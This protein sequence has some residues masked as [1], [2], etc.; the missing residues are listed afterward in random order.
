MTKLKNNMIL[1]TLLLAM[2]CCAINAAGEDR[3]ENVGQVTALKN[4]LFYHLFYDAMIYLVQEINL[5]SHECG[6]AVVGKILHPDKSVHIFMHL[7]SFSDI[8][9][10]NELFRFG[11]IHVHN[12]P[13]PSHAGMS[14]GYLENDWQAKVAAE[15]MKSLTQDFIAGI[16]S[17]GTVT[18]AEQTTITAA[19]EAAK[20]TKFKEWLNTDLMGINGG[21]A[22]QQLAFYAA[23]PISAVITMFLVSAINAAR[24]KRHECKNLNEIIINGLKHALTPFD[25]VLAQKGLT[26]TEVFYELI[27]GSL[28]ILLAIGQLIYGALP[29]MDGGDGSTCWEIILGKKPTIT[30]GHAAMEII[31]IVPLI[32]MMYKGYKTYK[33]YLANAAAE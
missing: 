19:V 11:N 2:N 33:K 23:G 31:N 30:G 12:N 32:F 5:F 29:I 9:P 15:S 1:V 26:K 6:H 14:Y 3:S 7:A 13:M 10:K 24:L 22:M 17:R 16:K 4:I 21:S 20:A 18:S 25:N 28:P 27:L 8:N